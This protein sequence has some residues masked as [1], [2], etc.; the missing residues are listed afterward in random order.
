MEE[1]GLL[2]P[3]E[4]LLSC[5]PL[6]GEKTLQGLV[7]DDFFCLSIEEDEKLKKGATSMSKRR[8][9]SIYKEAELMGSS[10]KDVVKETKE[11]GRGRT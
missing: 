9:Q 2:E 10:D 3:G 4:E 7:I 1:G 6:A 8:S 11:D 5:K